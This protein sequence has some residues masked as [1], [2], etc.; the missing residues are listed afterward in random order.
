MKA[1][2][3]RVV[4]GN[5][6]IIAKLIQLALAVHVAI[7]RKLLTMLDAEKLDHDLAR[8]EQHHELKELATLSLT[9]QLKE[10]AMRSGGFSEEHGPIL[11][12][13]ADILMEDHEWTEEEIMD[14]FGG[15]V[16]DEE[17][18]DLGATLEFVDE[19]ELDD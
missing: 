11:S 14:W 12:T 1:V 2:L 18:G 17:G 4:L 19:D 15:L 8:T 3:Y 5:S 16:L 13:M 7:T 9:V 10:Q 6:E